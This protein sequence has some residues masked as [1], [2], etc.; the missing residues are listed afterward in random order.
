L[1]KALVPDLANNKRRFSKE[2]AMA[3]LD[4]ANTRPDDIKLN[5]SRCA[6]TGAVVLAAVFAICWIGAALN[7]G[8][9]HMY[10]SLFAI[11]APTSFMAL[12]VGL[13]CSTTFGLLVGALIAYTYNSLGFVTRR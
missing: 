2:T 4:L 9:S 10:I 5:V 13:I 7:I 1:I 11:A 12:A 3:S 6:L 8:G